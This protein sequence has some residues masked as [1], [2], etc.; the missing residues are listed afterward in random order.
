[1]PAKRVVAA[2]KE[3]PAAIKE[4]PASSETEEEEGKSSRY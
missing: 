2:S 4:I 3:A 1:M